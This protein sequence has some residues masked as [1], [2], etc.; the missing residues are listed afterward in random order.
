MTPRER[1]AY[2][3]RRVNRTDS[4]WLTETERSALKAKQASLA[5]KAMHALVQQTR[6][7]EIEERQQ[8]RLEEQ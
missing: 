3:A 7:D 8:Q 4:P 5:E 2:N 1:A 6:S